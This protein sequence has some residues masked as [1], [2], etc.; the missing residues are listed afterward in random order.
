MSNTAQREFVLAMQWACALFVAG[1]G[2]ARGDEIVFDNFSS[3]GG[4]CYFCTGPNSQDGYAFPF[5]SGVADDFILMP[6]ADPSGK[7][8]LTALSWSGAFPIGG[9]QPAPVGL[10]NIIIW[11]QDASATKPAG[12]TLTG[13]PD[14][15]KAIYYFEDVPTVSVQN[16]NGDRFWDYSALFPADV[17]LD[18]DVPYW[19]EVQ[20][21][22][23]FLPYWTWQPVIGGQ[24][25]IPHLGDTL[26]G[27]P[28]WEQSGSSLDM[29]FTL[30]GEAVPEPGTALLLL[31]GA[32]GSLLR[33]RR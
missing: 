1:C 20:A 21:V 6:S 22:I 12:S 23:G 3:L 27:V 18:P 24:G 5:D 2:M 25:G 28:F 7:W 14:Y 8:K 31:A 13:G 11:P 33:R 29:S 15:T 30:Y 32:V 26:L 9:G 16:E 4:N 19:L 10:F 17:I